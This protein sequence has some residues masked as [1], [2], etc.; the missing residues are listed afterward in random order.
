MEL[1][2]AR[3]WSEGMALA[4]LALPLAVVWLGQQYSSESTVMRLTLCAAL[5][6]FLVLASGLILA[7]VRGRGPKRIVVVTILSTAGIAVWVISYAIRRSDDYGAVIG[8]L[9]LLLSL[10]NFHHI[11]NLSEGRNGS[12]D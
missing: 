8:V 7:S 4:G 10:A 3:R 2:A 6:V 9:G 11:R 1:A 5:I 12:G